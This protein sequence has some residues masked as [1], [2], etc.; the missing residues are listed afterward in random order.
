M[1]VNVPEYKL[2]Q[3]RLEKKASSYGA[4]TPVT[5]YQVWVIGKI[6]EL[7]ANCSDGIP[8]EWIVRER[9]DEEKL[10]EFTREAY[11]EEQEKFASKVLAE[12][13]T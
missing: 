4:P 5:P 12:A 1:A 11:R 9:L 7:Y 6:G 13:K 2:L 10:K 8:K 3:I